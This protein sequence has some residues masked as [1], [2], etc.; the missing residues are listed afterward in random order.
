MQIPDLPE[1]IKISQRVRNQCFCIPL[2]TFG[3]PVPECNPPG[4]VND[5]GGAFELQTLNIQMGM[6]GVSDGGCG[7]FFYTRVLAYNVTFGP[8]GAYQMQVFD[9]FLGVWNLIM[10]SG[11]LYQ[12]TAALNSYGPFLPIDEIPIFWNNVKLPPTNANGGIL[13]NPV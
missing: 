9:K 13:L 3:K 10:F 4:G 6:V 7:L 12:T 1:Y 8:S 5:P 11:V 2:N